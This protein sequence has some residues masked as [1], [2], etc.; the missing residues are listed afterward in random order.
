MK[1]YASVDTSLCVSCGA[2]MKIC[3][4]GAI[5]IPTGIYAQANRDASVLAVDC[6][7]KPVRQRSSQ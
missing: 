7:Q 1:R 2:C 5:S 3:P 4:R 6:V